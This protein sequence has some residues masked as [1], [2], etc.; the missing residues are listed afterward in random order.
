[1]DQHPTVARELTVPLQLRVNSIVSH[2][3]VRNAETVPEPGLTFAT[4]L[5]HL[6]H[7]MTTLKR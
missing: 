4:S 7:S 3:E 1:M 5:E 6:G 2:P